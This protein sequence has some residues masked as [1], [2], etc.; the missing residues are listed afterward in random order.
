VRHQQ[1][2]RRGQIS[3]D[4]LS[5]SHLEDGQKSWPGKMR[6]RLALLATDTIDSEQRK[7]G[8]KQ[9]SDEKLKEPGTEAR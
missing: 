9:N 7:N 1:P 6:R 3:Y 2:E 5:D 4:S 8:T